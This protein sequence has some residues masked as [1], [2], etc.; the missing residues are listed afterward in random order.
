MTADTRPERHVYGSPDAPVTILE[1]GDLECPYCRAAAPV[2]REVVDASDGLARLVWRH[3]PLFE[4]HPYALTAALAA[5]AAA[6]VGRF[7]DLHD[8]L[9]AHQDHLAEPD[10]RRYARDLGIDPAL[11]AG[12]AAQE[13]APSVEADYLAGVAM[14]VR[15]T[16]TILVDGIVHPGRPQVEP[17]LTAVRTAARVRGVAR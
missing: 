1:F 14:G 17:L 13:F 10:L 15:G 2:L 11:V 9:L 16:P 7:W 12:P 8:V 6:T 5:E 3:F 4:V